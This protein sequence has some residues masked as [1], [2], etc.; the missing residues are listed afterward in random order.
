MPGFQQFHAVNLRRLKGGAIWMGLLPLRRLHL[1]RNEWCELALGEVGR[2]VVP[3]LSVIDDVLAVF[4]VGSHGAGSVAF[5][6][7]A[8][9]LLGSEA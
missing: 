9:D 2:I 8:V 1:F 3:G 6:V 5:V 4:S 7:A